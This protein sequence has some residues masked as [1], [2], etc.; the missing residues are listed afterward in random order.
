MAGDILIVDGVATNRIV[1]KVKLLA[2]QYRVRP[3]AC[4]DEAKQ[5]IAA[6]APDLILLDFNTASQSMV[7]FCQTVRAASESEL[8]PI[9]VTGCFATP[10]E[11]VAALRAGADD[12]LAKPFDDNILQARIRSLLRARDTRL[13]L[14]M[15]DGTRTALGLNEGGFGEAGTDFAPSAH[16]TI[17]SLGA[18]VHG[19]L[20]G[21][22]SILPNTQVTIA[23]ISDLVRRQN[24]KQQSDLFV[25]DFR[26]DLP[27]E[28]LLYRLLSELR[29]QADTRRAG[30]LVLLPN[31][32]RHAAAMG[33]DLGANDIV[34]ATVNLDE[35]CHR[36]AVLL[37]AKHEADALRRTVETG[38][39]AAITD[40]LTGLFNRR[41]ALPHLDRL[42]EES[43][44]SGREFAIMVLD[45]D[46]FKSIND[47]YGH[48]AGDEILQQVA[49]RLQDNL[50]A[51]DLLARIGGEEFLVAIPNSDV[52]H[53][54]TAAERL[55]H[56]IGDTPFFIGGDETEIRVTLSV[57]VSLNNGEADISL[58]H[59]LS[60]IVSAA[61][62][63]LYQAKTEGRNKVNLAAA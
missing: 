30:I 28:S 50:R 10:N 55:R 9:I 32:A 56:L 19:D 26:T 48:Q 34:C 16:I 51:V 1:L 6:A 53:A 14:K 7:E 5:E 27:D 61:D 43:R 31:D 62:V 39:K 59:D 36:C 11:R 35:I 4:L 42:F 57:G 40:P 47:T 29:T 44:V 12:V 54:R 46:H 3:C 13:E 17:T 49:R 15:R 20:L 58:P 25:L 8:I 21:I 33:L 38:L 45:I 52:V 60:E 24:T 23:T 18:H 41:Y 37:R 2:A 22:C 63:A